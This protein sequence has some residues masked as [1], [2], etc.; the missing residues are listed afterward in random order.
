MVAAGGVDYRVGLLRLRGQHGGVIQRAD[1]GR[2]AQGSHFSFLL[3]AAH[4]AGD[5]MAGLD[6]AGGD[7]AADKPCCAGDEYIHGG[8][9]WRG[10]WWA[11]YQALIPAE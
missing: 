3:G 1:H 4:Q 8:C 10:K 11:Q 6:Q 9:S 2:D 7:G 5:S